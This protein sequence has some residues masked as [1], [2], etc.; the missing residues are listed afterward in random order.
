MKFG[1]KDETI[2]K[3]LEN[4]GKIISKVWTLFPGCQMAYCQD[5]FANVFEIL[6]CSF[7]EMVT[8]KLE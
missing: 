1:L 2:Q 7:T 4:N 5:P 6:N 8:E 3:I